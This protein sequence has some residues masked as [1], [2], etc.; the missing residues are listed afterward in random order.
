MDNIRILLSKKVKVTTVDFFFFKEHIYKNIKNTI[1]SEKTP[2][3]KRHRPT[4]R[5]TDRV[6][7][8]YTSKYQN[9]AYSEAYQ[10][11]PVAKREALAFVH[12][13]IC[14]FERIRQ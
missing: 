6:T 7:G 8:K 14:T 1:I 3:N 4:N 2:N 10:N 11:S 5:R 9:N 12:F 13:Y